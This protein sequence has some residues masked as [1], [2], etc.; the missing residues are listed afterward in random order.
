MTIPN[1]QN[2]YNANGGATS[3]AT[4]L[5]IQLPRDPNDSDMYG[6]D[7]QYPVGKRWINT[8]SNQEFYLNGYTSAGG[9]VLPNWQPFTAVTASILETLTGID[10]GG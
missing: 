1:A 8:L 9:T 4:F 5:T 3:S 2:L 10:G 6:Q 7:G